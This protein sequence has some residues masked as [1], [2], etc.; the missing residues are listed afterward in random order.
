M[1]NNSLWDAQT[2]YGSGTQGLAPTTALGATDNLYS[3]WGAR[4]EGQ[5]VMQFD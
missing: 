4:M 3:S 5:T 2:I 1:L